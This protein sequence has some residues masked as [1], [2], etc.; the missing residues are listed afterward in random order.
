MRDF[1]DAKAMAQ[2]LR[3]ALKTRSIT[4]THSESLE[5]IARTFGF[6]DWNVL[7]AAIQAS[8][9]APAPSAKQSSPS[10]GGGAVTGGASIGPRMNDTSEIALSFA[11]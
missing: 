11:S 2:T 7:S 6:H 9:A 8:D 3:D 5:V 4:L 1:R 10:L